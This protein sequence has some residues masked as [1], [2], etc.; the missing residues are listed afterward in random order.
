MRMIARLICWIKG[1]HKYRL[2]EKRIVTTWGPLD[3]HECERCKSRAW[4]YDDKKVC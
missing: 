1:K 4:F 2:L 3:L